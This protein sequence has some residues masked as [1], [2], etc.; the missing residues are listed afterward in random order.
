MLHRRKA[1]MAIKFTKEQKIDYLTSWLT[2]GK[3][4]KDYCKES[5]RC[6]ATM[7][8]WAREILGSDYT[9]TLG[10]AEQKAVLLKKI[11]KIKDAAYSED[12]CSPKSL[13][14]VYNCKKV[15]DILV[16]FISVE[17]MGAKISINESSI[18]SVFRALKAVN[19]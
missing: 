8:E 2:S 15:K 9:S 17:Y 19:G 3:L 16:S 18:E 12:K 5:G 11:E 10:S 1:T 4:L 13:V 14:K 7:R 6:R